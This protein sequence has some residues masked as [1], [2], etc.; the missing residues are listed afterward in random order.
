[1]KTAGAPKSGV[2]RPTWQ[3]SVSISHIGPKL[4]WSQGPRSLRS[5]EDPS[6]LGEWVAYPLER[7]RLARGRCGRITAPWCGGRPKACYFG[8][9]LRDRHIRIRSGANRLS[10]AR[11]LCPLL[12]RGTRGS[13]R[14]CDGAPAVVLLDMGQEQRL[15]F[16]RPVAEAGALQDSRVLAVVDLVVLPE[17]DLRQL[18]RF[19]AVV[20][21]HLL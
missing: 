3:R 14:P 6:R 16:R 1:M 7:T 11:R 5:R 2:S 10:C 20:L 4:R 9:H 17:L 13:G 15:V 21:E 8:D 19:D 12:G 18:V